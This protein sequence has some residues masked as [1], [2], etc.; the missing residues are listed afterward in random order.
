MEEG[1][2]GKGVD[3]P[4][5]NKN[6]ISRLRNQMGSRLRQH[7]KIDSA[8]ALLSIP[9]AKNASIKEEDGKLQFPNVTKTYFFSIKKR[10]SRWLW[11]LDAEGRP[12]RWESSLSFVV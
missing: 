7:G 5:Y 3:E 6:K 8:L 1:K 4:T 11:I 2:K 10:N 12:R 9:S